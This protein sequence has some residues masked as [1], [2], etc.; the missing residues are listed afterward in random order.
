MKPVEATIRITGLVS[1]GFSHEAIT[2]Q[3]S[4]GRSL[5]FEK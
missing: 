4:I 2:N 5:E 1:W 3:K